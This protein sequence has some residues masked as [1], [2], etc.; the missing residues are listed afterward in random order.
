M[1]RTGTNQHPNTPGNGRSVQ[2]AL[3]LSVSV[4][5]SLSVCLSVSLRTRSL[6]VLL[7]LSVCVNLSVQQRSVCGLTKDS[8]H[9][10]VTQTEENVG[11]AQ[12]QRAHRR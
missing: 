1:K 4:Y 8:Q 3:S 6:Y 2:R 11:H 7:H 12:H 9:F 5:L 10:A